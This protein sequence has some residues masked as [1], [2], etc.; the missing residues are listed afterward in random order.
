MRQAPPPEPDAVQPPPKVLVG[1]KPVVGWILVAFLCV[2][3]LLVEFLVLVA[4]LLHF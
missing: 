1:Q 4:F 3:K 2:G